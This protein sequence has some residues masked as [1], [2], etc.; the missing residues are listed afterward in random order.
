MQNLDLSKYQSASKGELEAMRA[1]L[2]NR[3]KEFSEI[4]E[5]MGFE[6]AIAL[7]AMDTKRF[8]EAFAI[9]IT[10]LKNTELIHA[11]I[12]AIGEILEKRSI[13]QPE[14]RGI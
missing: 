7:K 3:L 13:L 12:F 11:G 9:R 2:K 8:D 5:T 1:V 4:A 6:S 14:A 10:A